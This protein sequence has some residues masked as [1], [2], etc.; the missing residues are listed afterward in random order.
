LIR[1]TGGPA[2]ALRNDL[3]AVPWSAKQATNA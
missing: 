2:M 1:P 3:E